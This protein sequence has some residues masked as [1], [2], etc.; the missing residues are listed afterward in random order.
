MSFSTLKSS[1]FN[2]G[3]IGDNMVWGRKDILAKKPYF[4]FFRQDFARS[5]N[6]RVILASYSASAVNSW[7]FSKIFRIKVIVNRNSSIS[8]LG[9]G[10]SL[11]VSFCRDA[12]LYS[13]RP[14]ISVRFYRIPAHKPL[15]SFLR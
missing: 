10:G 3:N 11:S 13:S 12:R 9:G 7:F 4:Y 5:Y 15:N 2:N 14:R 8:V 1:A 6:F